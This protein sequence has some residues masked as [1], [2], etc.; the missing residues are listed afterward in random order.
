MPQIFDKMSL[1]IGHTARALTLLSFYLLTG[2]IAGLTLLALVAA[3]F[4]YTISQDDLAFLDVVSLTSIGLVSWRFFRRGSQSGLSGW[5]LLKR[6]SFSITYTTLI[7][8][9][10]LAFFLS[11]TYFDPEII[12]SDL[13]LTGGYEDLLTY[14]LTGLFLA[15]IYG[16]TP[17]PP[18]ISRETSATPARRCN[19]NRSEKSSDH[20]SEP[21]TLK[22]ETDQEPK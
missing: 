4:E 1:A 18:L 17:L 5:G 22:P 6:F 15:V 9:A 3:P 13:A 10:V 11:A 2:L 20:S 8:T 19:S 12:E 7:C 14:G 16:S 21:P